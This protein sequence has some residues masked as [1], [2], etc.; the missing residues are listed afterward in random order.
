V[1][2]LIIEVEPRLGAAAQT[3]QVLDERFHGELPNDLLQDLL[4]VVSE[5]VNN[6]V[7]HGPQD[8]P[9]QT[10]VLV[11]DDGLV[12]GKVEDGGDPSEAIAASKADLGPGLQIVD[13]LVDRWAADG[14]TVW[15]EMSDTDGS[16]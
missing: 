1:P 12:H 2:E 8:G 3:R 5:L 9:I 14:N 10:F 16:G 11:E 13:S 6:S 4:V 7:V 15:F